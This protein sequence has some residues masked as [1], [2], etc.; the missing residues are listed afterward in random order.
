MGAWV[1]R[2]LV[3]IG[4]LLAACRDACLVACPWSGD[5]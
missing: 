1:S 2:A 5:R 3:L 4:G